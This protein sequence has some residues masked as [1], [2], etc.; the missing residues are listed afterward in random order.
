[1]P[2]ANFTSVNA[3][4]WSVT[5][6]SPPTF[7]P[8]ASPEA[9][10][11]TRSGYDTSGS[12]V[13]V[14]EDV[15][16][17]TRIRQ[18][19]PNEASLTSDQVALSDYIYAGETISGS[20]TNNSTRAY[21]KPIAMWLNHD[22]ERATSSTHTLRL[23]VAHGHARNG[24]PVAAV[25]FSV[26]DGTTTVTQV[27]STM[28]VISYSATGLSVP[29]FAA[30][31]NLST[32]TQGAMLTVD[33]TI[34]PWVGDAF[35]ISTDAD[36]YPSPNLTTLRLLNDRTGAYGTAYAYVDSTTGNNGTAVT[37]ATPA[38]A[39]A[40]PYATIAGAATG[41]KAYNAANFGRA[42]DAGGGIVRLVE[43]TH[44][45]NNA[46]KTAGTSVN[47]PMIVEAADLSKTATTILQDKVTTLTNSTPA[48]LKIRG[49]TLRKQGGSITFLD[50]G[51]TLGTSKLIVE[52]CIWDLN[53]KSNYGAWVYRVGIFWQINCTGA[54]VQSVAFSNVY[55][56]SVIIGSSNAMGD[57]V[58]HA[59]GSSGTRLDGKGASG[60]MPAV[61]GYFV[62]WCKLAAVSG[63]NSM[64][65]FDIPQGSRGLAIVGNT[66]E[67]A[68]SHN[69]A[70]LKVAADGNTMAV[71]NAV[72]M[73]NTVAGDRT[74]LLY[75]DGGTNAV[76]SGYVK[77]NVFAEMNIKSD[78]FATTGT[79]I[80]NWSAR[81]KTGWLNNYAY[82]SAS[83]GTGYSPTQ[84]L[85]EIP[86]L[87]EV[88][89]G[90]PNFTDDQSHDGGDAGGGDY[91]PT[92]G[93]SMPQIP[94][95][96]APWSHDLIG[97]TIA[98]D[99]SA[100]VGA[101]Q[102]LSAGLSPINGAVTSDVSVGSA[103]TGQVVIAGAVTSGVSVASVGAGNGVIGGAVAS[104]VA[105]ASAAVGTVEIAGAVTSPVAVS[106]ASIAAVIISG[107][108]TSPIAVDSQSTGGSALAAINGAVVSDVSVGSASVGKV[109]ISGSVAATVDV[110]SAAEARVLIAGSVSS[111]VAVTSVSIG[112]VLISGAITSP[113]DVT[114]AATG[115]V[116]A[117]E[118][119]APYALIGQYTKVIQ[120]DAILATRVIFS[121]SQTEVRLL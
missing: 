76:K 104:P 103:S 62:G 95:G 34:Y 72:V 10:T 12:P 70:A 60:S 120:P 112:G 89:G 88:A 92:S 121:N 15:I 54:A 117:V 11:V 50:S 61:A 110:A 37:S 66:I 65:A 19:Y 35:T 111:P 58:F 28:S 44:I 81:F 25:E 53:G 75:V 3:D 43:G 7:D 6:P 1:M 73:G 64:I 96:L 16:C 24:T 113:I 41:I 2:A 40:L 106:V 47:I 4:G 86:S 94:A 118:V 29:H 100:Y 5:Y 82:A 80:G 14:V 71:E 55:K 57:A 68:V 93:T 8:V 85:G 20:P 67:S 51:A 33:A 22:R 114:T 9:A 42:T 26:S 38:V 46:F 74:N 78:V 23:A 109:V 108:I 52:D 97:Q 45:L 21:P 17:M 99:G 116:G 39:A 36:T 107:S 48:L 98:D 63:A 79:S 90:T 31:M 91:A 101:V 49:L 59:V 102:M 27:V 56:A 105:V 84:W 13:S 87:G 115:T 77:F 83:N 119:A 32:L 69:A 18:A 30:S